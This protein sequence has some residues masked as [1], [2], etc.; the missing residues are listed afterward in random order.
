MTRTP[1]WSIGRGPGSWAY[2]VYDSLRQGVNRELAGFFQHHCPKARRILE[3]GSGPGFA[4]ALM[5][6]N[7][8][9]ETSVALDIDLDAINQGRRRHPTLD[10]VQ[11]DLFQLPFADET[12][13]LVWNSSTLEHLDDMDAAISEMAR[14]CV[15]GGHVFVGVPYRYGPMFFQRLMAGTTAGKW[16]GTVFSRGALAAR[17]RAAGLEPVVSRKYFFH[18]F[19]GVLA[20]KE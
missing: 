9:V 18:T 3:V 12:F 4:S 20:C 1:L 2:R 19:V 10:A 6:R 13:H 15:S 17:L 16:I 7:P 5:A 11:G 8:K 14:V